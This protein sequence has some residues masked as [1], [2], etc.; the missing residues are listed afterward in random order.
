MILRISECI[1]R[2]GNFDRSF[3]SLAMYRNLL[4]KKFEMS[5][6][7]LRFSSHFRNASTD[8]VHMPRLPS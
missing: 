6:F 8:D 1:V 3:P 2:F 4:T 7:V 5:G